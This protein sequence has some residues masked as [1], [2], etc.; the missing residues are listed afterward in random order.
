MKQSKKDLT[1]RSLMRIWSNQIFGLGKKDKWGKQ[2]R[3]EHRGEN[4]RLSR[5]G[6]I[7]LRYE[8]KIGSVNFTA[9]TK[10]GFRASTKIAKGTRV[11][12]QNGQFRLTGRYGSGPVKYNL[13]KSGI[14]ASFGNCFGSFNFLK[15]NYS[16]FKIAGIQIRGKQAASLQQLYI[17]FSIVWFFLKPLLFLSVYV[18]WGFLKTILFI[19]NAAI[20]SFKYV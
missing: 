12:L 20:Y 15:P 8:K 4:L 3:L 16:S 1:K 19:L 5:T 2:I 10:R 11:A 14:S 18:I 17:L 13:S 6:G 7:S 9:N